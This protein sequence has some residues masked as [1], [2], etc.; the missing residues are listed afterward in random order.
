LPHQAHVSSLEIDVELLVGNDQLWTSERNRLDSSAYFS[1]SIDRLTEGSWRSLI[2]VCAKWQV[3][4]G[5]IESTVRLLR[6]THV[7]KNEAVWETKRAA[8]DIE[9]VVEGVNIRIV[10]MNNRKNDRL[11]VARTSRPVES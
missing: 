1:K 2:D 7:P 5:I 10:H 4:N 6:A 8:C 11:P 3:D 9:G